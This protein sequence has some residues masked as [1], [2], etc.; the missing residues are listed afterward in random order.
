MHRF[1]AF[2]VACLIVLPAL[3]APVSAASPLDL[4]P[5]ATDGASFTSTWTDLG[6]GTCKTGTDG[7]TTYRCG[8]EFDLSG[9][10]AGQVITA[11][12]L[13]VTRASGC[14]TNDCPVDLYSFP[15]TDT[16][17][18]TMS[19]WNN[20]GARIAGWTPTSSLHGVD[21]AAEIRAHYA[22]SQT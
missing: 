16:E 21:V 8:F 18:F 5:A 2:A 14:S 15:G 17:L 3:A 22:A 6:S 20:I 9:I 11:A 10:P 4:D 7:T 12:N 1:V 19:A 13:L